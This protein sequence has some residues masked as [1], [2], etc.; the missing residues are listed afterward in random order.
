MQPGVS[1]PASRA[2]WIGAASATAAI[3]AYVV[4]SLVAGVSV[5]V[6]ER[7][8]A[9]LIFGALALAAAALVGWRRAVA[10][11]DAA[12][13]RLEEERTRQA[14]AERE[15]RDVARARDLALVRERDRFRNDL[16][17]EE[18][19]ADGLERLHTAERRWHAA[20]RDRVEGMHRQEGGEGDLDRVRE[21]LLASSLELSGA[22]KGMLITRRPGDVGGHLDV[23]AAQGVEP[24]AGEAQAERFAAEPVSPGTVIREQGELGDTVVIPIPQRDRFH[25]V[26]IAAGRRGGFAEHDDAV[27]VALG[28]HLG[29]ILQAERLNAELRESYVGALHMLAEAID[30]KDPRLHG[31][32]AEVARFAEAMGRR[33][34]V[35][36]DEQRLLSLASLLHDVGTVGVSERVLLKPGP[37]N[38]QER[39]VVEEHP[40]IGAR[41]VAQVPA[42]RP[43]VPA[44]LHH[45]ER[46]DGE[47]YPDRLAG[48]DIPLASRILTV[49]D[50]YVAMTEDRQYRRARPRFEVDHEFRDCSGL[51]FDPYVVEALREVA[52][53]PEE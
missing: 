40:R 4:V 9:I 3:A 18:A 30:A 51:Q 19:R 49:A 29:A 42:L 26:L 13:H 44:I 16:S 36:P 12:V 38:A 39:E 37:L 2:G 14:Q 5:D 23:V 27:L 35:E 46:Y 43:L 47:G 34:E 7:D 28:E 17:R 48:R 25:G 52:S 11:A 45:H 10:R 41:V 1:A 22:T 50:A 15:L 24:A 33:L 21:V 20:L 6:R 31:H 8:S 32:S 53:S